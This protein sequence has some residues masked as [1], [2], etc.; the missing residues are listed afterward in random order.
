MLF[1]LSKLVGVFTHPGIW[2]ILCLFA[3]LFFPCNKAKLSCAFAL[4][5]FLVFSNTFLY[6]KAFAWWTSMD[7]QQMSLTSSYQSAVIF[8]G[9]MGLSSISGQIN[10]N[11]SGDRILEGIRLYR[12]GKVKR[13]YFSG[14]S[15]FIQKPVPQAQF[16]FE[17]YLI[18]MGVDMC[19]VLIDPYARNT[20]ENIQRFDELLRPEDRT[21][22][23]LAISSGWHLP[24]IMKGFQAY[25][26]KVVP[27]AVDMPSALQIKN[28]RN[29][30]PSWNTIQSWQQLIKE[31]VGFTVIKLQ[32]KAG[33]T[34]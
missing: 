13:L 32:I 15:I 23:I 12:M 27:Y 1:E 16:I 14:E 33:R 21:K 29:L 2:I 5:I 17:N 34:S 22:P 10:F 18:Q 31:M 9:G 6:A 8:G 3:G 26:L 20:A 28:W 19:D 11:E 7:K 25:E 4:F 30:L 24:R